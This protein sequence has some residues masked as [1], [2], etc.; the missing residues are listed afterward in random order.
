LG[1]N[2]QIGYFAQHQLEALDLSASPMT[3]IQRMSPKV[4]EQ[5]IRNFLGGFNFHDTATE[6]S[7]NFSGGEKARLALA[8]IVWQ[9]P[10]L[11]ILD[12]PTNHLDLEM[13]HAL[14][15]ALQLYKGAL[16]IISHDRHLLKNT[17]DEFYLV[18]HHAVKLFD[19]DLID[20]QRWLKESLQNTIKNENTV[21]ANDSADSEPK[22]D[23][24]VQRQ[25]EA[26]K[27]EQVKPLRNLIKKTEREIESY[28]KNLAT[29]QEKLSHDTIYENENKTELQALL[30]EQGELSQL[31]DELE[32]KWLIAQEELEQYH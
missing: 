25:Q 8:L 31:I 3:H 24:K 29:V 18:A 15:L 14:T 12:E 28:Q 20:Y 22:L 7:K 27:R 1:D 16:V 26:A 4:S 21:A 9:R 30:K 23:K 11:L 10:N 13:R 2:L 6:S 32:E 19:G 17:V 5:E